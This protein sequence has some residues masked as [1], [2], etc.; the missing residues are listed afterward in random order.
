MRILGRRESN[1]SRTRRTLLGL[2]VSMCANPAHN[3]SPPGDLCVGGAIARQVL[4]GL[5]GNCQTGYYRTGESALARIRGADAGHA[6]LGPSREDEF[7]GQAVAPSL[8][9]ARLA[10]KD[11]EGLELFT[12]LVAAARPTKSGSVVRVSVRLAR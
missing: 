11:P 4:P 2:V 10:L 1:P 7:R 12:K 8:V 5:V 9:S 3:S 6:F